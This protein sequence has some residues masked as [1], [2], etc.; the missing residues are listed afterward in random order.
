MISFFI[1]FILRIFG[2]A[3]ILMFCICIG[4]IGYKANQ[5]MIIPSAPEGMTYFDFM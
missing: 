5:P 4:F 2:K 1:S 3:V